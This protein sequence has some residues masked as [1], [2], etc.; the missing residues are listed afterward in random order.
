[1]FSAAARRT[2]AL[3]R[4][5][6][7]HNHHHPQHAFSTR[8]I[9]I[10]P[11]PVTP[12][13]RPTALQ[14]R[15][16]SLGQKMKR[17]FQE[18][19][20]GIWRKNPILLPLALVSVATASGIFAYIA[21]VEATQVAPQYSKFPLPVAE[22]LRTAVY[23]TDVDLNPHKAIT[24][25]KEA[26]MLGRELGMHPWSDEMMGI[27]LQIASVLEKAGLVPAA[28]QLLEKIRADSCGWVEL[29]VKHKI[30]Q[31]A[32]NSEEANKK[33]EEAADPL[34]ADPVVLDAYDK[35]KEMEAFEAQQR[36]KVKAKI[37]GISMKLAELYR[38]DY[39][40]NDAKAEEALGFA[41][42]YS[43]REM[44]RRSDAGLPVGGGHWMSLSE[45]ASALTDLGTFYFEKDQDNYALPLFLRALD[46]VYADEGKNPSCKQVTLLCNISSTIGN[47]AMQ[48]RPLA[49]PGVTRE[50]A[51]ETSRKWAQEALT[52]CDGIADDQDPECEIGCATAR[53]LLGELAAFQ[54]KRKEA[55][56]YLTESRDAFKQIKEDDLSEIAAE[57]LEE[58]KSR[59]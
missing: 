56:K 53:L 46:L 36:D 48:G 49:D 40:Q 42:D 59:K 50:E 29:S 19:S 37:V 58:V 3:P 55:I 2:S 4:T 51:I 8:S 5:I 34:G 9:P 13:F 33:G 18:A 15:H 27:R 6:I 11:R 7:T 17:G 23:Y 10:R 30:L 38:S 39:I 35:I 31:V 32:E 22:R 45:I 1:M 44:Q 54:N 57:A 47:A 41:V 16:L 43:L 28:I 24:A 14:T 26:F 20:K 52:K 12:L 21:Y 25:Y